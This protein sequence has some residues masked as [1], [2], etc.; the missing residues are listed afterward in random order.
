MALPDYSHLYGFALIRK[1]PATG[2]EWHVTWLNTASDFVVEILG[3]GY[4]EY[5]VAAILGYA[6]TQAG[7]GGIDAVGN[8]NRA[9]SMAIMHTKR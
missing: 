2:E 8:G 6:A 7:G 5:R 9:M 4:W 3:G 1:N